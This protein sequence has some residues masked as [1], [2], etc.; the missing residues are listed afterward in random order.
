MCINEFCFYRLDICLYSRLYFL[1]RA[2]LPPSIHF[3]VTF[4]GNNGGFIGEGITAMSFLSVL[5]N[6]SQILKKKIVDAA[7]PNELFL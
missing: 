6:S 1:E 4:D 5:L 2:C 7:K 3:P